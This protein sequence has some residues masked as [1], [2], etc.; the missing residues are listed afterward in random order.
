MHEMLFNLFA[1][2]AGPRRGQRQDSAKNKVQLN[3]II[4]T[5]RGLTITLKARKS[6]IGSRKEDQ[7]TPGKTMRPK[8]DGG[9]LRPI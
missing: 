3:I 4:N 8:K 5:K 2:A 6:S 9:T 1:I 7:M